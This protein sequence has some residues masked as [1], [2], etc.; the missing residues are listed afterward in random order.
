M[1]AETLFKD[2]RVSLSYLSIKRPRGANAGHCHLVGSTILYTDFLPIIMSD[3]VADANS[4]NT[5]LS[6]ESPS[7]VK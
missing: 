3:H 6:M 7:A 5:L 2:H 4:A 1:M